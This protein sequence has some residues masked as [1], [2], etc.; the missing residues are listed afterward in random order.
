MLSPDRGNGKEATESIHPRSQEDLADFVDSAALGLHWVAPDGTILWANKSDYEPLGYTAE[1][2][3]GH[4]ITEFHADSE[5]ISDILRRLTRGEKLVEY[6]ARLRCKDGSVR[7]V[8]ITS[9]VRFDETGKFLHTRCFTRDVTEHLRVARALRESEERFRM[10]LA[11]VKDFAIFMLDAGGRVETWNLGAERLYGHSAEEIVGQHVSEL[12]TEEARRAG[13]V[14]EDL[15]TA[16]LHGRQESECE[17][18]RKDGSRYWAH[19][20]TTAL[21]D[22]DGRLRG[23]AKV[24]RDVTDKRKAEE[25]RERLL[26]ELKEAVA[27]RDEFLS[28]ASHELKTPLTSVKLNLRA[29]EHRTEV[30]AG[31]TE[32]EG[33][34]KLVRIHG[35]ID[36]L[37]KLVNSLLDVSRITANRL[38]FH[39]EEVDLGEVLQDVLGQFK[40]ELDRAGCSLHLRTDTG[41]IGKWDRLRVDQVVS[42]LLS[43][44]IKYGPGRPVEVDLQR[45][46]KSA[47]LVVRDHGIG[48]SA[49]DQE[50]IFQRFERAV[51]IQHYGGFGLGLWISR[52]IVDNLGG[53]I[54]VH[55]EPGLGSTFIVE[56]P[57]S[58][59]TGG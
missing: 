18:V 13:S 53:S 21:R 6:S 39:L 50:R 41:V 24:T 58:G 46:G 32:G 27:A 10:L 51:S 36:R 9:S 22:S 23:F 45:L 17:R 8:S 34:R 40:E 12:Y 26:Q 42:N 11:G 25:E 1:E 15:S 35:Q 44:A 47:R 33:G 4:N 38:D 28:I 3:I 57:L 49:Q 52:Q 56:L 2:Y 5:A 19:V 59:P 30:A 14:E 43:N 20:V 29:L 37:A 54:A 48:I 55:S 7:E 16:S 31:K